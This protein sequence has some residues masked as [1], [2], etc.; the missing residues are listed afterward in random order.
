VSHDSFIFAIVATN[1]GSLFA[2]KPLLNGPTLIAGPFGIVVRRDV[3]LDVSGVGNGLP[4]EIGTTNQDEKR[5]RIELHFL[6]NEG[7]AEPSLHLVQVEAHSS[8]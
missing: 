5:D 3:N 1:S 7:Q 6:P 2:A 4:G 8:S